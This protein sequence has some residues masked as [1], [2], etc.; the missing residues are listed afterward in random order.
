MYITKYSR[1]ILSEFSIARS[2]MLLVVEG[3][4]GAGKSTFLRKLK[5]RYPSIQVFEEAIDEWNT[6]TDNEMSLLKAF[7][8]DPTKYAFPLQ[9]AILLS[10]VNQIRNLNPN[11]FNVV[12][13]SV[14]TD[15][16]VFGRTLYRQKRLSEVEYKI[17]CDW[18]QMCQSLYKIDAF[19][20]IDVEPNVC[21]HRVKIR[22]REGEESI[23]LGYLQEIDQ[24]HREW[25]NTLETKDKVCRLTGNDDDDLFEFCRFTE[26]QL[27]HAF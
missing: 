27:G 5:E 16:Q 7:Y 1:L 25:F 17:I 15:I 6:Y 9:M 2:E 8:T 26:T 23:N 12:E 13:R 20:Y 14:F 18:V 3:N 21:Q 22:E 10:R 4:I 11:D 19:V 24:A